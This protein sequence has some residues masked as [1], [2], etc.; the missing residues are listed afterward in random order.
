MVKNVSNKLGQKLLD[1]AK[2]STT[3]AIKPASK[4]TIQK[5]A[6]ATGDLIGNKIADK[7]TNISKKS[8]ELHSQNNEANDE[9]EIPR[10]RYIFPEKR[11]Q[12]MDE[13]K[14]V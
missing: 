11:Q 3:D 10:E 7:I 12:I 5:A 4:K 6:E 13:L 14:L 8:R 1:C 2:K 9:I